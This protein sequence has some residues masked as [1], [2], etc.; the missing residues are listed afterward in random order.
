MADLTPQSAQD[1]WQVL[2]SRSAVSFA[3][4]LSLFAGFAAV[5]A[6]HLLYE[7]QAPFF[8]SVSYYDKLHQVMTVTREAGL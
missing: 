8:D 6:N 4:L 1:A 7:S 5:A 3:L 2:H